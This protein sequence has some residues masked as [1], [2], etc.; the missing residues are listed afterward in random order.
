MIENTLLKNTSVHKVEC[1]NAHKIKQ[2]Y[3]K[4]F[5]LDVSYLFKGLNEV[6]IMKCDK[7]GFRFYYPLSVEGDN[8]F[9]V[10]LYKNNKTRLYQETKWEFKRAATAIEG[11]SSVLDVGCGAGNFFD[12]LTGKNCE[13]YGIDK[14][15][16]AADLLRKKRISFTNEPIEEYAEKNEGRFDYI[17]GFQIL[18]HVKQPGEFIASMV[19]ML[20]KN[21]VLIIAVPNNEPYFLKYDKYHTLNLPPHHM[22]LWNKESLSK[23]APYFGLELIK[24]E[25]ENFDYLIQYFK[26]KTGINSSI[27]LSI[28]KLLL[29]FFNNS[30]GKRTALAIYKKL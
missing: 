21:G 23:M 3:L 19:K 11:N 15:D 29:R 4:D 22:G 27:I 17:T 30:L 10:E 12:E 24:F 13:F 26:R 20:K 8:D 16:Y 1:L 6:E 18:E 28:L 9:Y 25:Y 14:S 5:K 7:T 2:K